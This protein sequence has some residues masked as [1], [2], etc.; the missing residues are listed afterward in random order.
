M[1]FRHTPIYDSSASF[2]QL[3]KHEAIKY[4]LT[5]CG[6]YI[7]GGLA[8]KESNHQNIAK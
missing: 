2:E 6:G 4:Y 7:A 5:E 1:T 3:L 8:E